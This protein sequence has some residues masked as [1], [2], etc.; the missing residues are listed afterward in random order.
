MR[1][2]SHSSNPLFNKDITLEL[3]LLKGI[4][5]TKATT[6]S[7]IEM[8]CAVRGID[9]TFDLFKLFLMSSGVLLNMHKIMLKCIAKTDFLTKYAGHEDTAEIIYSMSDPDFALSKAGNKIID[10]ARMNGDGSDGV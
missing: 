6:W 3:D 9:V 1:T 4:D 2:A 7:Q 8:Q 5:I 10:F